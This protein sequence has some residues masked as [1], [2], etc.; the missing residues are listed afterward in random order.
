MKEDDMAIIDECFRLLP[1]PL[2]SQGVTLKQK[3]GY[4]AGKLSATRNWCQ[5][6]NSRHMGFVSFATIGID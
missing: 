1:E 5:L 3:H 6:Q 4:K 2:R